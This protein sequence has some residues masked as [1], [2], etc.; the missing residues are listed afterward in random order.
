MNIREARKLKGLTKLQVAQA[1]GVS[2]MT[3]HR[4]EKGITQPKLSQAQKLKEI[5]PEW[6]QNF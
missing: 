1:V 2:W 4:W 3:F 6:M 5:L